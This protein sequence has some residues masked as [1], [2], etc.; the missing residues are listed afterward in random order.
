MNWYKI[1][2]IYLFSFVYSKQFDVK[3]GYRPF[4]FLI[5]ENLIKA[6]SERF[7]RWSTFVN[8]KNLVNHTLIEEILYDDVYIALTFIK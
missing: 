8:S 1:L 6:Q 3:P 7:Q 4:R 5:I 2:I